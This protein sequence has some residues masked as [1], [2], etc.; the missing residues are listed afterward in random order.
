MIVWI[1]QAC[2]EENGL[3]VKEGSEAKYWLNCF[4]IFSLDLTVA[5]FEW[6]EIKIRGSMNKSRQAG[7]E[8]EDS[9]IIY[10]GGEWE[11][12]R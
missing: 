6:G 9:G 4:H 5:L 8:E 12:S 1:P 2:Q 3:F 10:A 7:L 11:A